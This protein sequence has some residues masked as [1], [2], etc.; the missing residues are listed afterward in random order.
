[1]TQ[2]T[3]LANLKAH[4]KQLEAHGATALFA[5]GSWI[6]GDNR[7][8]SNLNV[9]IEHAPGFVMTQLDELRVLMEQITG[10]EIEITTKDAI[11]AAK[12]MSIN[13]YAVQVY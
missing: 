13:C 12:F 10:L 1:M 9:F 11:P 5:F 8:D 4:R 7:P 3:I 6:R 2:S